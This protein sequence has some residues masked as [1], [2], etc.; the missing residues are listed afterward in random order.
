MTI[1]DF[2][3]DTDKNHCVAVATELFFNDDTP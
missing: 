3:A 1:V 2:E